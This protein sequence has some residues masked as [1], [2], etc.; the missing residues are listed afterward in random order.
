MTLFCPKQMKSAKTFKIVKFLTAALVAL[1]AAVFCYSMAAC[2]SDSCA[3]SATSPFDESK[4]EYN[5]FTISEIDTTV[6]IKNNSEVRFREQI[7][8]NFHQ[9]KRG[10]YRDLATNSGESYRDI[11]IVQSNWSDINHEEGFVRISLGEPDGGTKVTGKQ[12]YII[13]YTLIMPDRKNP[14]DVYLNLIGFGWTT[15]IEKANVTVYSPGLLGERKFFTDYGSDVRSDKVEDANGTPEKDSAGY[16]RY[17]FSASNLSAFNGITMRANLPDGTISLYKKD[18]PWIEAL[19]CI[20]FAAVAVLMMFYSEKGQEIIEITHYYPPEIDGKKVTPPEAGLY[21]DGTLSQKD[22]VSILFYWASKGIIGID[23][24]DEDDPVLI[25]K[26]E[27]SVQEAGGMGYLHLFDSIFSK[28]DRVAVS[29]LKYK[30]TSNFSEIMASSRK[31]ASKFYK[32]KTTFVAIAVALLSLAVTFAITAVAGVKAIGSTDAI[33]GLVP[34]VF[35][36]A[37]GFVA[38]TLLGR[39]RY[40]IRHYKVK[41]ILS[42]VL[43]TAFGCVGALGMFRDI[44]PL[45]ASMPLCAATVLIVSACALVRHRSETYIKALGDLLGVKNFL[46]VAEKDKLEMLLEE[47]P[48]YYYDILPY[49]NVLGVSDKWENKFKELT[50]QPPAYV[51]GPDL[52]DLHIYASLVRS[53]NRDMSAAMA[54]KPSSSSRSGFGGFSGGGGFGGGGF[55]GGGGGSR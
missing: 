30:L 1:V 16:Y 34:T 25:K 51:S 48:Q 41:A 54:Q 26:T 8:A 37:I 24:S 29:D 11:N 20:V 32:K 43:L 6:W 38:N 21:I 7:T 47:N 4:T 53:L 52:I 50:I 45:Y 5:V 36:S 40:K 46:E 2:S 33:N 31:T 10:I 55:G 28:G 18:F 17:D 19:L 42:L 49:A 44:M 27:I 14:D 12:T 23:N 39:Y 13:E 9:W 22:V 35:F 15:K 3:D